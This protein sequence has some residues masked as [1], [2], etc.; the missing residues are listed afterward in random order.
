MQPQPITIFARGQ[1]D[2]KN[3]NEQLECCSLAEYEED[4]NNNKMGYLYVT[5]SVDIPLG[6]SRQ[7]EGSEIYESQFPL[8]NFRL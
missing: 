2:R 6:L 3:L 5:C 4:N 1:D 7:V 8:V